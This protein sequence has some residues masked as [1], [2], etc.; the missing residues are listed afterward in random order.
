M[1]GWTVQTPT[2]E[3]WWR[4][5]TGLGPFAGKGH[6]FVFAGVVRVLFPVVIIG[7]SGNCL[8]GGWGQGLNDVPANWPGSADR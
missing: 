2:T 8:G 4:K 7:S 5:M 1:L 3:S 6:G